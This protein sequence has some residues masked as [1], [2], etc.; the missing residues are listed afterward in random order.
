LFNSLLAGG[1]RGGNMGWVGNGRVGG[2]DRP[3]L[4]SSMQDPN[5]K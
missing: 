4:L 5:L 3:I 1:W 2:G